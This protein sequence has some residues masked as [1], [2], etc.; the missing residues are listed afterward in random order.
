MD[1]VVVHPAYWRRGH[2]TAL[3]KWGMGIADIDLVKQSVIA[4]D[5][6]AKLYLALG[7]SKATDVHADGD[8]EAP[9]GITCTVA[10][11]EPKAKVDL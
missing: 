10:T 6:G 4:A 11:Y 2:G 1:M 9:D 5:M 8:E 7:Y 3:V